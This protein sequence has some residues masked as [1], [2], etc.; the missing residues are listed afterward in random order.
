MISSLRIILAYKIE[1]KH[2]LNL[3]IYIYIYIFENILSFFIFFSLKE[4]VDYI[5]A[6]SIQLMLG[7][8]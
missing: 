6:N 8:G 5:I 1:T 7:I 3:F 2:A 4:D